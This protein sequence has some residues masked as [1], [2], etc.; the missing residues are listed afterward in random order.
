MLKT[1]VNGVAVCAVFKLL[2]G[3]PIPQWNLVSSGIPLLCD[4]TLEL[5]DVEI[6][7]D[8]W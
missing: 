3:K 8:I 2:R 1:G 5:N 7:S 4:L 6:L